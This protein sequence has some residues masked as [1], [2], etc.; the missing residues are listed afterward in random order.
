MPDNKDNGNN[1]W[2]EWSRHVL[3]ELERL[4]EKSEVI[5]NEISKVQTDLT[6]LS[7]IK[8]GLEELKIWKK[9]IDK[10][11]SPTQLRELKIAVE[12]LK[13]FKT[14]AIA[15]FAVVQAIMGAIIAL[16]TVIF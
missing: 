10:V 4:N 1:G 13:Q 5:R 3:L 7:I 8:D 2:N 11:A 15:I 6:K 9:N 14:K 16:K 12:D